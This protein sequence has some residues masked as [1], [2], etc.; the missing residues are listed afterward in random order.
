MT[1]NADLAPNLRDL[2]IR[3]DQIG[4]TFNAH[5]SFSIHAFFDPSAIAFAYVTVF[6]RQHGDFQIMFGNEFVMLFDAIF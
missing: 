1:G 3:A 6:V 4:G 2:A 5:I